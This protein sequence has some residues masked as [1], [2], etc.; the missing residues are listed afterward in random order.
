MA[1][2]PKTHGIRLA[3]NGFIENARFEILAADPTP[4]AAG[5]LWY[6][7]TDKR[8]KF[9]T[10]D[11]VNAVVVRSFG[12]YEELI[13]AINAV[14]TRLTAVEGAFV[15]KDGSV[16]F[17]GDVDAGSNKVVN[18]AA[19]TLGT[20][21]ANK[22]YVD[23][24]VTTL[25]NSIS[26][27]GNAFNLIGD[28]TLGAPESAFNMSTLAAGQKDSGDY[29]HVAVAGWYSKDGIEAAKYANVGDGLVFDSAGDIF[30][31]DNTNSTVA[32]SASFVVVTGSPDTGYTVDLDASFKA[33]IDQLETDVTNLQ[34]ELDVTQA[35]AGLAT[36]GTHVA[37]T[38]TNHLDGA[39]SL[40]DESTKLDTALKA[41][42][43]RALAAEGV[44]AQAIADET[45][46]ATAAEGVNAQAITDETTRATGVEGDLANLGTTAKGNLVAAIN[47]VATAAGE[48][49][50]ALKTAINSRVFP[51]SGASALS[52]VVTHN[53]GTKQIQ[54]GQIF[55]KDSTDGVWRNDIV[56]VERAADD[57]SF[58]I[59]L[60]EA[61]EV[62]VV[63][64]DMTAIA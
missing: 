21:A 57:N 18:V 3:E 40:S 50:G 36:D 10:L 16:A 42:E 51:Y 17:T 24:E 63:V 32:G 59:H 1:N 56:N 39:T 15:N 9:S 62:D 13:A 46:R 64:Q 53:F 38:G 8:F 41:E 55:V 54:I 33:R 7:S 22:T 48:G 27:L 52:H 29:H 14:D 20:D 4:A 49:T 26:A 37:R 44:N 45:T 35:G 30:K 58:T 47:E 2:F 43:T 25:Q 23:G 60:V 12:S 28:I 19:P 5:R 11:E 61:G 6:N 31:I 34:T